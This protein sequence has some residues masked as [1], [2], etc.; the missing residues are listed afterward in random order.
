MIYESQDHFKLPKAIQVLRNI[1]VNYYTVVSSLLEINYPHA[2]KVYFSI[3]K[4]ARTTAPTAIHTFELRRLGI[5]EN[6]G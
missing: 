5:L 4:T 3:S 2:N 6:Y 1:A